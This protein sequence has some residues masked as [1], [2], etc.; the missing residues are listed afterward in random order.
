MFPALRA[1]NA[2]LNKITGPIPSQWGN[3]GLFKLP[4]LI[5][6]NGQAMSHVFNVS[7]NALTGAVPNFLNKV[8]LMNYQSQGVA[9]AVSSF[10]RILACLL[11]Q[12][13][14]WGVL[15]YCGMLVMLRSSVAGCM[16]HKLVSSSWPWLS[17]TVQLAS[18]VCSLLTAFWGGM[19]RV[20]V[21]HISSIC[22]GA[23]QVGAVRLLSLQLA[24][25]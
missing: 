10:L 23:D 14:D 11:V 16:T 24:A 2:S 20:S 22:V 13:T 12:C 5:L 18:S 1:L 21:R 6:G 9:L 25:S 4:A 19:A 17:F 8:N 15:E 7:N 3:T